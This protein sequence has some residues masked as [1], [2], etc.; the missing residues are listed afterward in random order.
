VRTTEDLVALLVL[1]DLFQAAPVLHIR[2]SHAWNVLLR[3][4]H[5]NRPQASPHQRIPL[6]ATS[7]DNVVE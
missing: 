5:G 2:C 1:Q 7:G 3:G 4:L 6:T